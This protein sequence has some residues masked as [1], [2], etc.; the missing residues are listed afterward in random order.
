MN[1]LGLVVD[2]SDM[3]LAQVLFLWK[4]IEDKIG[5]FQFKNNAIS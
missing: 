2:L 4:S 5:P 3:M 1:L